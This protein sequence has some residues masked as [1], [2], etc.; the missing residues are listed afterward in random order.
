MVN[1]RRH[2]RRLF[3]PFLITIVQSG[4]ASAATPKAPVST[5]LRVERS[6]PVFNVLYRYGQVIPAAH[7][8]YGP[9]IGARTGTWFLEYQR[10]GAVDVLDGVLRS[11]VDPHLITLGL[12]MF[13]FG[14]AREAANGSFP[15]SAWPFHGTAFFLSEAAPALLALRASPDGRYA[16]EVRWQIERMRRAAYYMVRTV[17]GAGQIDDHTKNHRWF[18]AA[19][20]LAAVGKLAGDT[21][22]LAWSR[23]YAWRGIRLERRDG[24]MPEDGGHDSGYQGWAW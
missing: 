2:L 7:G 5:F 14:L 11:P 17:G 23:V 8:A 16:P 4:C 1:P 19:I 6:A 12:A 20:A 18:E 3:L 24:V 22:L 21:R 9:N 15:G 10:A 13:H